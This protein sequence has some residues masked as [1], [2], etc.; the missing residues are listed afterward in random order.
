[1]LA[2]NMLPKFCGKRGIL[3]PLCCKSDLKVDGKPGFHIHSHALNEKR[4]PEWTSFSR[5]GKRGIRTPGASQ[6]AGFQDRCNRPLYH[7]SE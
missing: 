6:H 4:R 1:M 3:S 7:L 5:C 2:T